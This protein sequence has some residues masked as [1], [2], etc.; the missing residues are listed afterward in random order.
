MDSIESRIEQI[1]G[2][3]VRILRNGAD[4]YGNL[5]LP[6]HYRSYER[7]ANDSATVH[8]WKQARFRPTF[9]GF[10]VEV[11]DGYGRPVHGS[12][13]LRTVRQSYN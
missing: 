3:R 13:S 4:A 7:K 2:F 12:T 6:V 5:E 8:E 1:E 11:L 9:V 10:D